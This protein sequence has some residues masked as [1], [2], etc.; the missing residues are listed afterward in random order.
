MKKDKQCNCLEKSE[1]LIQEKLTEKNT[2][3]DSSYKIVNGKWER[4][5]FYPVTRLYS[6]YIIES[7]Y[8]KKD[9]SASKPKKQSIAI[10]YSYCP[11]CGIEY[12]NSK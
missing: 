1:K 10:L 3:K 12:P 6:D 4:Q 11:F 8:Q 9:G 5:S 2:A 7:T